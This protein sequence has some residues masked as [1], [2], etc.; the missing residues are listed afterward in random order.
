MT[1]RIEQAYYATCDDCGWSKSA[2]NFSLAIELTLDQNEDWHP[3][4]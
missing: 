2:D 3:D 4:E 1:A